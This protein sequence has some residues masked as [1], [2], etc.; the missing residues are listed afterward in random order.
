VKGGGP[1][2][3]WPQGLSIAAV[4]YICEVVESEGDTGF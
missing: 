2:S 4:G 1:W 3:F